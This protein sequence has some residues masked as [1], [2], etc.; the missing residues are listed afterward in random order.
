MWSG[1]GKFN[2]AKINSTCMLD[3]KCWEYEMPLIFDYI[4]CGTV[5]IPYFPLLTH[6]Q[7]IIDPCIQY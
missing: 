2:Y 4:T 6:E 1:R 7:S 5:D 3:T